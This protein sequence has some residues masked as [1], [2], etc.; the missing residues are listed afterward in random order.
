MKL[1]MRQDYAK[2]VA[3]NFQAQTKEN[4]ATTAEENALEES[5]MAL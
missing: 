1:T 2:N 3:V 4:F 5:E